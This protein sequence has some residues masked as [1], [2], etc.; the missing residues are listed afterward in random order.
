[1]NRSFIGIILS[2]IMIFSV[3]C[4]NKIE[5]AEGLIKENIVNTIE[6]NL[7]E[8]EGR[9]N[10]LN[11]I[12]QTYLEVAEKIDMDKVKVDIEELDDT[13]EITITI[14]YKDDTELENNPDI[15]V[16]DMDKD[17]LTKD[18]LKNEDLF[19]ESDLTKVVAHK[20]TIDEDSTYL[21]CIEGYEGFE[22]DEFDNGKYGIVS[23]KD[24]WELEK[25]FLAHLG[26]IKFKEDM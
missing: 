22:H 1:M 6:A 4:Q 11:N 5:Q 8:Y 16:L 14:K 7:E 26:D 20:M 18:T 25:T 12:Q 13:Y 17:K 3:G 19:Y 2:G 10:E 21:Y 9:Y 23:I 24:N 15:Y